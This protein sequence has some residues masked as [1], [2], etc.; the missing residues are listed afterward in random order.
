MTPSEKVASKY[1]DIFVSVFDRIL[2]DP[3]ARL[4]SGSVFSQQSIDG[5]VFKG[6]NAMLASLV[7]TQRGFG[8]PLWLT[9]FRVQELGLLINRGEHS[10]PVVHY[11]IYYENKETGKREPGMTDSV[12][13]ALPK[14]E[15][16]KYVKRCYMRCYPEFNI[17]QTNF[18]EMYPEQWDEVVGMFGNPEK[19]VRNDALLDSVAGGNGKWLCPVV[20]GGADCRSFAY[21]EKY[22][23][24]VAPDKGMYADQGRYYSDFLYCLS[25]STGSEG[26]LDRDINSPVLSRAAHEEL[27]SELSAATLC[28]V[29]G[30]ESTIRDH[31]L[32]N[33]KSWVSAIQAEPSE[34]YKAVNE[35]AK[36]SDLVSKTLGFEQRQGFDV[37]KLLDGVDRAQQAKEAMQQRREQRAKAVSKGHRKGWTPVKA[38][39]SSKMKI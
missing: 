6:S 2:E 7:A 11:D 24:I 36:A 10:I 15:Q 27:V 34:I 35:A 12:Y 28:T 3:G 20:P 16:D 4:L 31:N 18:A 14:E 1:A 25:R 13:K 19:V 9:S 30:L 39:S 17:V 33:L 38:V 21:I 8:L 26:R 32:S 37:G 5:S 29:C 23:K 22:D